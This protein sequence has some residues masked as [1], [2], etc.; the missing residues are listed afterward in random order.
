MAIRVK[1]PWASTVSE[2]SSTPVKV[3]Y[4]LEYAVPT[5]LNV[6]TAGKT[7]A[8]ADCMLWSVAKCPNRERATMSGHRCAAQ[9]GQKSAPTNRTSGFPDETRRGWWAVTVGTTSGNAAVVPTASNTGPG[10]LLSSAITAP[11]VGTRCTTPPGDAGG[12][13]RA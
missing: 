2:N 3:T 10:T 5:K 8:W 13:V 12:P 6:W 11:E 9:K 1:A 7:E 4:S